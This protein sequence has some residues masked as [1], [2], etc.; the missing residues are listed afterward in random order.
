MLKKRLKSKRLWVAIAT[1]VASIAMA[2]FLFTHLSQFEQIKTLVQDTGPFGELVFIIAYVIA[3]ILVLPSTAFNLAAGA[4]FGSTN[5]LFL[6]SLG[7]LLSAIVAFALTRFLGKRYVRRRLSSAKWANLDRQL[8]L[9]GLGYIFA[10]RLFPLIPYGIVSFAA[11]LCRVRKRDYIIG[12]LLGTPI[13]LSPFVF[14]GSSGVHAVAKQDVLP[15]IASFTSLAILIGGGTWYQQRRL[16][17]SAA[18]QRAP[19]PE[20]LLDSTLFPSSLGVPSAPTVDLSVVIPAYN[21]VQRLPRTLL[22][23]VDYL[24]SRSFSFEIL[25]V[26]DGSRDA[27]SAMVRQFQGLCPEVRLISSPR[28][29]GKG[30]SV[31]TGMLNAYG[32]LLLFADADGATPIAEFAR[33]ERA[34]VD[35]GADVAIGSRA[36]L[37]R[38][39]SIKTL[40]HRKFIG[41]VFNS[42]VNLLVVPGVEDTQCGFKLFKQE[43]AREIFRRQSLDGFSFDVEILYIAKQLRYRIAEI[44]VNWE[45]QPGSKVRIIR[46]SLRMLRDVI[47]ILTRDLVGK[48]NLNSSLSVADTPEVMASR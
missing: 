48:Y 16:A 3:T 5:G 38:D 13:G 10:L 4:L 22:E 18:G 11:G 43:T 42:I 36:K 37:S 24:R 7:S 27:T 26:D 14:L 29:F 12:T 8:E 33:L 34:I 35:D 30:Y 46:D 47:W 25:V 23:I 39:V 2:A 45:N 15:L 28:N 6:A 44:P 9:G 19:R 1:F 41:R 31:R 40:A 20:E 17:S 32:E 21:E